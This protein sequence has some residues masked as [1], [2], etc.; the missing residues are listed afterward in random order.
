M[1]T[2]KGGLKSGSDPQID[3]LNSATAEVVIFFF[4]FLDILE[5]LDRSETKGKVPGTANLDYSCHLR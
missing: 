5:T 4:F 3:F 2:V 1:E